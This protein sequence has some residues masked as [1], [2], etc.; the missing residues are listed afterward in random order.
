LHLVERFT[1]DGP[2]HIKYEV[3]VEDPTVYTRPWKLSVPLYRRLE[4]DVRVLDYEC[5]EYEEPF[6]PWHEPPVPGM[7]GPV[8]K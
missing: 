6:V 1:P 3:T 4:K 8:K 7:P 5:L 2:R